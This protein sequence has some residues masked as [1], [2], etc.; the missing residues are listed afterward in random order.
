MDF[1][2][3]AMSMAIGDLSRAIGQ[4]NRTIEICNGEIDKGNECIREQREIIAARNAAITAQAREIEAL[5]RKLAAS[6]A[7]VAAR[8]ATIRT[9]VRALA[10]ANN[11]IAWFRGEVARLSRNCRVYLAHRSGL[12]T[13]VSALH[14]ALLEAVPE[15]A[16]LIDVADDRG[17]MQTYADALYEASALEE[18]RKL[19]AAA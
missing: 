17:R 14:L 19:E 8:D 16:L 1:E 6:E 18:F 12:S 15:H 11:R 2:G 13:V 4:R 9:K 5:K 10:D 7:A 3:I